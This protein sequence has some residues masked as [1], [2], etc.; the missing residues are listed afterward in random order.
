M[1]FQLDAICAEI[2]DNGIRKALK[3][4]PEDMDTTYER[5]LDI[6]KAKPLPQRE[7][8]RKVLIWTAHARRPLPI[9]DLAFAIS[10]EMDMKTPEAIKSSIPTEEAI[11]SVCA[12]LVSVDRSK[13]RYVRFVHFSVQEFLT[14][15]HSSTLRMGYEVGHREIAQACII[16]LNLFPKRSDFLGYI[17]GRLHRSPAAKPEPQLQRYALNEWPHHLLAGNLNSLL[18]DDPIVA[19]TL[20]FFKSGPGLLTK[21]PM[22]LKGLGYGRKKKTCLQFSSSVLMLIF[23]LPGR[24]NQTPC[25]TQ[26]EKKQPKAV[27]DEDLNCMVLSDDNLAIHYATAEL[28]SVPVAQRL[29]NHGYSLNYS[30]TGHEESGKVQDWLQLSP[31]YSVQST[32][33]AKYLLDNGISIEPQGLRN[34]SANPL[35]YFAQKENR[36]VRVFQLLLEKVVDR[37]D[38]RLNDAL[39]T[40]AYHGNIEVTRLLLDK[41]VDVN[42]RGG[43]YGNALQAAAAAFRGEIEVIR[44]LLDK[45]ANVNAQGGRY[46]NVLQAAAFSG[47]IEVIRLLL[48]K[49]SNVN[50]QGG[51]YGSALQAA[52]FSGKKDV[53]RLLLDKGADFNL[54]GG[55]CSNALQAA[56]YRGKTD[57][58]RLLLDKGADIHVQGGIYGNT[59]QAAA[60]RGKKEVISL[61]LAKGANINTQGGIFGTALQAAAYNGNIEAIRLLLDQGADIHARAGKYGIALKEMLELKSPSADQKVPGDIPLL[62]ELLQD[63]AAILM[64]D[65]SESQCEYIARGLWNKDRCNLHVFRE[66]LESRGWVRGGKKEEL[67]RPETDRESYRNE[68][69]D[70]SNDG[71]QNGVEGRNGAGNGTS[72]EPQEKL[73]GASNKSGTEAAVLAWKVFGFTFLALLFYTLIEFFWA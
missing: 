14:S 55:V 60:Y 39:Q 19:L 64:E 12:N 20:S 43:E 4:V 59:L 16:F 47:E 45:G 73:L 69:E 30:Y 23:D 34:T 27:Y 24:G 49:G 28:D 40:A 41:G 51:K 61:L 68:D 22:D 11:L 36:G 72:Q 2:S 29:C 37:D 17:S 8:A 32:Q 63:H 21:Q 13:N 7:L 52:V 9:H 53:I 62:V 71:T 33:M 10:I 70:G 56:V 5:I 31:L 18:P 67:G 26:L 44:L 38:G 35:K 42:A 3:R 54:Q 57:I 6:I 58:I 48:D 25:K 65:M 1:E 15:H 66:L 50:A 46:G